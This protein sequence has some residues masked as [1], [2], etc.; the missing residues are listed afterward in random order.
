[1]ECHSELVESLDNNDLP[2]H[3][4]AWWVGKFPQG[5]VSICDAQ[6]SGRFTHGVANAEADGIQRFP[7]LWQCVVIVA[8]DYIEGL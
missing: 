1:M 8:G 2:Y 5:R 4:V 7:H 6:L 3:A